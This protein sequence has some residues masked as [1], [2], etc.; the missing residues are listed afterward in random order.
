MG[1]KTRK[2]T[3]T[4]KRRASRTT[5]HATRPEAQGE[6]LGKLSVAIALVETAALAMRTHEDEPDFGAIAA[7]L[8]VAVHKLGTAYGEIDLVLMGAS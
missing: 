7:S 8:T 2:N 4:T 3:G 5:R 1:T 6:A